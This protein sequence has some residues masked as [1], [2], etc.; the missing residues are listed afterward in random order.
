MKF[1]ESSNR[2]IAV[3]SPSELFDEFATACHTAEKSCVVVTDCAFPALFEQPIR[4]NAYVIGFCTEGTAEVSIN[5]RDYTVQ[6]GALFML[7]PGHLLQVHEQTGL[8]AS[9]IFV[10]PEYYANMH[11]DTKQLMPLSVLVEKSVFELDPF[12]GKLLSE[13]M[14]A[15]DR[16][17]RIHPTS[18][19]GDLIGAM[20]A[21]TMYKVGDLVSRSLS[22]SL[23]QTE[24]GSRSEEYFKAFLRLLA[25]H[26][27]QERMVGFYADCLRVT[28]KYLTTLVKKA[29][30]RSV[31]AWID[32]YVV[33]E[34]KT[35]LK[36]SDSSIY[37]I[38][39]QL[40][41]PNQSFFGSYFRRYVGVSPSQYR[42]GK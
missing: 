39:K 31:S 22:T 27:K 18:F 3:C 29:S 41:F 37:D 21:A 42:A 5:M 34:A 16:E 1:Q 32:N 26:Y 33:G 17:M 28:P 10:S 4:I 6:S 20:I 25:Q 36:Y 19:T 2:A 15:L 8:R 14:F 35:L 24:S 7:A 23:M 13:G 40:N 30:G 38:A 11:L 9:I 12:D